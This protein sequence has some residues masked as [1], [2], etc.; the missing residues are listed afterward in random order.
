M[1]LQ[2]DGVD[3]QKAFQEAANSTDK[4][5]EEEL[6]NFGQN[7]IMPKYIKKIKTKDPY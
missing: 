4:D 3:V 6:I 1:I 7:Q 2:S 5:G